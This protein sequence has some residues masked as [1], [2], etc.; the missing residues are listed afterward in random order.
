MIA[1]AAFLLVAQASSAPSMVVSAEQLTNAL[2]ICRDQIARPAFAGEELATAGWPKAMS[3]GPDETGYVMGTYRHPETM[4]LIT[5]T[6]DP[7]Q[8]DECVV[9]APLGPEISPQSATAQADTL[10]GRRKSGRWHID[11]A[12]IRLESTSAMVRFIFTKKASQ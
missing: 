4:L 12:D 5:L 7:A 1:F 8:S 11:A 10:L 6:H 2:G 9:M 3:Q